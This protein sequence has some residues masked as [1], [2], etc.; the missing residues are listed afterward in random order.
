[1]EIMKE[2][3]KNKEYL[4]QMRRYFHQYP[5]L[6]LEEFSTAQKIRSELTGFHLPF[7]KV[8]NTGTIAT[9]KGKKAFPVIGIRC[10]MDAL[11]VQEMNETAYV[12]KHKGLMHACGH[13]SHMA[14]VLTLAKILSEHRDDLDCTVKLIF[15]PGEEGF[16]GAQLVLD[17]GEL[18]DIDTII[19]SHICPFIDEGKI[20]V[21]PG[22]RCASVDYM[23]IIIKGKSGH[24]GMPQYVVDPIYVGSQVVNALQSIVSREISPLETVVISLC[25]FHS[26]SLRNVFAQDAELTGTIR[27]FNNDIQAKLPALIERI[28]KHT[29]EAFRA[30]YS[31]EYI[32]GDPATINNPRFSAIA[33]KSVEKVLSPQALETLAPLSISEDFSNMLQKIPGIYAF[34]GC[35]NEEKGCTY[36]LHHEK[37]NLY[38]DSM[39]SGCAF[40]LQYLLD[41][42][43]SL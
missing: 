28:I 5:E 30:S 10:D 24:G 12:S 8:A 6:S 1:M 23:K 19:G 16:G 37:F 43:Y 41:V 22:P 40:L 26:G 42:Q 17:S 32:K 2:I 7:I 33:A 31:F 18:D 20:S 27:T 39:I 29:C 25:T 9:V 34:I 15:Q 36:S 11:P 13:D 38:E 4:F 14:M 3:L 35:R 21:D